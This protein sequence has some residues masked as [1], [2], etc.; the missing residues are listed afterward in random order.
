MDLLKI[1]ITNTHMQSTRC[2]YYVNFMTKT[3]FEPSMYTYSK[4]DAE[5]WDELDTYW[6]G[7]FSCM[8]CTGWSIRQL[9]SNTQEQTVSTTGMSSK[10]KRTA[11]DDDMVLIHKR[12]HPADVEY[13]SGAMRE[14]YEQWR[15]ET[16]GPEQ[17][18]QRQDSITSTATSRMQQP[19]VHDEDDEDAI[20]RIRP[21]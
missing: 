12:V 4:L 17:K 5:R 9:R 8:G 20:A 14:L 19:I 18:L 6:L 15:T 21:V 7:G 3:V 2:D 11:D 13:D 1:T 16:A 10:A